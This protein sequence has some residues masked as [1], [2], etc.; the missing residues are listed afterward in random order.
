MQCYGWISESKK[1]IAK[2]MSSV[3]TKL[4]SVIKKELVNDNCWE[5]DNDGFGA[6]SKNL[7]K[8]TKN[9]NSHWFYILC[10]VSSNY[11][12]YPFIE[13][14]YKS[15]KPFSVIA[16]IPSADTENSICGSAF[17]VNREDLDKYF[18]EPKLVNRETGGKYYSL[19]KN[20]LSENA[21]K[22]FV[23]SNIDEFKGKLNLYSMD[24]EI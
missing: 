9:G 24:Q 12:M 4:V 7:L 17:V 10:S 13:V 18:K 15:E 6:Q 21:I 20:W 19:T 16:L 1:K 2:R 3:P 23:F 22:K 11:A 5:L 8:Y 14:I